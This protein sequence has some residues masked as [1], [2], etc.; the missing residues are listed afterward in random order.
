MKPMKPQV[1]PPALRAA[2]ALFGLSQQSLAEFAKTSLRSVQLAEREDGAG[3]EVNSKLRYFYERHGV[4]FL[5]SVE[6]SSGLISTCGVRL[7]DPFSD[8]LPEKLSDNQ[9][10]ADRI[11][12]A[13]ARSFLDLSLEAVSKGSG[14]NRQAV[15]AL[16]TAAD[17]ASTEKYKKLVRY[18]EEQGIEFLGRRD[19]TSQGF[20]GVGVRLLN[21]RLV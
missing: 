12:F 7:W 14:I 15:T 18:F 5:G 4:V 19:P 11:S 13:A 1:P 21:T 16:V 6:I 10:R 2:R 9:T 8:P 17:T 3:E 20:Y